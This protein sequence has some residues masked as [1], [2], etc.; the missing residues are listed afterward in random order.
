MATDLLHRPR[1]THR[2]QREGW[3]KTF[4]GDMP[5]EGRQPKEETYDESGLC[6]RLLEDEDDDDSRVRRDGMMV[7]GC[8]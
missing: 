1:A 5:I 7:W 3:R 4:D 6:K 2:G 8:G